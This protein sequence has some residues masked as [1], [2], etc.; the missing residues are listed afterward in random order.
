MVSFVHIACCQCKV[1]FGMDEATHLTLRRSSTNFYCPFGH[2]QH[3]PQGKTEAEKLAAAQAQAKREVR[4][5]HEAE[6]AAR[7][8]ERRLAAQKGVTTRLKNRVAN[9][10]CPCCNRSF[11]NLQRHMASQHKGFAA[12]EVETEGQTLQ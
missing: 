2:Q 4:W 1:S 7:A 11:M 8:T 12:E 9:G 3:F 5:R 10:V 6:E